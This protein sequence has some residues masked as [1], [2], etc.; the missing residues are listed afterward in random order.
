MAEDLYPEVEKGFLLDIIGSSL[1]SPTVRTL[2][3]TF[4]ECFWRTFKE[5]KDLADHIELHQGQGNNP[6]VDELVIEVPYLGLAWGMALNRKSAEEQYSFHVDSNLPEIS[7]KILMRLKKK[8]PGIRGSVDMEDGSMVRD[9]SLDEAIA[10]YDT[11][12][13]D[14][15]ERHSN[16]WFARHNFNQLRCIA[17]NGLNPVYATF[18]EFLMDFAMDF[19]WNEASVVQ[20]HMVTELEGFEEISE[21]IQQ[22][23]GCDIKDWLLYA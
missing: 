12:A 9:V 2:W 23:Y 16:E 5:D 10:I 14:K 17:E 6:F 13:E 20:H 3:G 19:S 15:H 1:N 18:E 8:M 11:T 21:K 22:V 4:Q 7:R